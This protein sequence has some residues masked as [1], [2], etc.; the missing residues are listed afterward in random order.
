VGDQ[1]L[2]LIDGFDDLAFRFE[3]D[4]IVFSDIFSYYADVG[5]FAHDCS[6]VDVLAGD[7]LDYLVVVALE[8]LYIL[9]GNA[10][11]DEIVVML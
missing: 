3:R 6:D 5:N 10:I 4:V 7:G 8:V 1:H 11:F 9:V 2:L